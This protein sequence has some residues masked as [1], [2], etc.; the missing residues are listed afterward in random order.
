M[1][2]HLLANIGSSTKSPASSKSHRGRYSSGIPPSKITRACPPTP[3][4]LPSS[5]GMAKWSIDC[6]R[7]MNMQGASIREHKR[8]KLRLHSREQ[9]KSERIYLLPLESFLVQVMIT[10]ITTAKITR[11]TTI[12]SYYRAS[13]LHFTW[14]DRVLV[15]KMG[16]RRGGEINTAGSSE[17]FN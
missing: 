5:A 7:G 17:E 1:G 12:T 9:A 6:N 14:T 15:W 11:M 10:I 4:L 13:R 3:L 2:A 16:I 8:I